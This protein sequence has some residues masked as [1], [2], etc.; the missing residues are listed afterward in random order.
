MSGANWD[1]KFR[2]GLVGVPELRGWE[3]VLKSNVVV[4]RVLTPSPRGC[5]RCSPPPSFPCL[6][7]LLL[8][9]HPPLLIF[10]PNFHSFHTFNTTFSLSCLPSDR[11]GPE[12]KCRSLRLPSPS[13]APARYILSGLLLF[14]SFFFLLF[15]CRG[16]SWGRN[17][18]TRK[19]LNLVVIPLFFFWFRFRFHLV[20]DLFWSDFSRRKFISYIFVVLLIL[21]NSKIGRVRVLVMKRFGF[22]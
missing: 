1:M 6:G 5:R 9:H 15:G 22:G 3:R 19:V 16:N 21:I 11:V 7:F 13:A 10:F 8:L 4:L 14:A 12:G 20:G 2:H 18:S 17:E